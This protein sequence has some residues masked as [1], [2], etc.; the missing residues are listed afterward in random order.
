MYQRISVSQLYIN[1]PIKNFIQQKALLLSKY[2][3]LKYL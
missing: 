3:Y 1:I 2:N